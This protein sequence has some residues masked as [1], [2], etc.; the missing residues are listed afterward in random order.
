MRLQAIPRRG[1]NLQNKELPV[2]GQHPVAA[3]EKPTRRNCRILDYRI[4]AYSLYMQVEVAVRRLVEYS[5]G[6]WETKETGENS[7]IFRVQTRKSA[8]CG[9]MPHQL[10]PPESGK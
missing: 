3:G 7:I 1:V 5:L 8:L 9:G 2:R 10:N 6:E 4:R